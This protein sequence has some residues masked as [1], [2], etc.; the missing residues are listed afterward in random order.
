MEA[1]KGAD[2]QAKRKDTPFIYLLSSNGLPFTDIPTILDRVKWNSK[3][4]S[5][6]NQGWSRTKVKTGH[7]PILDFGGKAGINFSSMLSQDCRLIERCIPINGCNC[8]VFYIVR[9][10]K[11]KPWSVL[12]VI[13]AIKCLCSQWQISLS[14]TPCRPLKEVSPRAVT[15]LRGSRNAKE[16]KERPLVRWA[17]EK[18]L[19]LKVKWTKIS[20]FFILVQF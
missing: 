18:T 5:P 2:T 14:Y 4:P 15:G 11:S 3:P 10:N 20:T 6:L 9:V 7:F 8:T 12:D 17:G 1:K 13:T 16:T 19:P